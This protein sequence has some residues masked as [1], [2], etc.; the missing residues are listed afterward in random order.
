VREGTVAN[1]LNRLFLIVQPGLH[2]NIVHC[3][4]LK[5]ILFT[6]S[7]TRYLNRTPDRRSNLRYCSYSGKIKRNPNPAVSCPAASSLLYKAA[8]H[9][10][11][12]RR[13]AFSWT[14][15]LQGSEIQVSKL[16]KSIVFYLMNW[17]VCFFSRNSRLEKL[18]FSGTTDAVYFYK[19]SLKC[20]WGLSVSTTVDKCLF[21]SILNMGSPFR[22]KLF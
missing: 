3:S 14:S 7:L 20:G 22:N 6:V 2:L 5:K 9:K 8:A 10:I 18:F 1:D 11:W 4:I 17:N 19:N 12:G 15:Q 21:W 13:P 16:Q